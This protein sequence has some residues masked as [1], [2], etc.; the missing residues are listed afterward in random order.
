MTR[1]T[2]GITLAIVLGLLFAL[3]GCQD[4]DRDCKPDQAGFANCTYQGCNC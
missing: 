2:A 3:G 4:K 1:V